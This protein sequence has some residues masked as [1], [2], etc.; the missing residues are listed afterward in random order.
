MSRRQLWRRALDAELHRW[1]RKSADELIAELRELQAYEI[2]FEDRDLQVEV[3]LLENTQDYVHVAL[4]VDDGVLPAAIV[5]S[6]SSF[7]VRKTTDTRRAEKRS[8]F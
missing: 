7:I 2:V 1:S 4:S 3:H 6:T 8:V 5:P